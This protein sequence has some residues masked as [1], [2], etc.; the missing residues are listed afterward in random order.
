MPFDLPEAEILAA[1]VTPEAAIAFWKWKAAL[2]DDVV[3]RLEEGARER[4]FYVAGL[5]ERDAV[6]TVKDAI[7]AALENG[8]T[9][10]DF[11]ARCIDI[12]ESQGWHD[13]RVETIYRNNMQT[14]YAAGR[15]AK[16]QEV[17]KF[18]PYWQYFIIEDGRARPAHAILN[19]L[20]FHADH[21][22]W[23]TNYPPNGHK[24]R[25]GVRTLSARQV[26]REGLLIQVEM[27]G[28]GM[29]TDPATGME[30]HV[31]RPGADDGWSGN[32]GRGWLYGL[33]LN[34]Y[35]DLSPGTYKEQRGGK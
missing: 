35:E 6:Q 14:A 9:L 2:P 20:V 10:A 33:D 27:P 11:K 30:Y 21:E 29:W 7:Q 26:E 12:I 22:F 31:A 19:N 8:E 1:P 5:A 13:N 32:P 17:K 18:R 23:I 25:C 4:A 24:C 3:K 34:K 28:D 16:M 15:Y